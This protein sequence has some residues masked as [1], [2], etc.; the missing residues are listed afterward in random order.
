MDG[1]LAD[2]EPVHEAS[3]EATARSLGLDL[4]ANFHD[5]VLGR[6]EEASHRWLRE[7]CGLALSLAEWQAARLKAYLRGADAICPMRDAM[8]AWRLADDAGLRQAVVSN[9]DRMVVEVNLRRIGLSRPGLVSVARNDVRRGKPSAEPYLR[10]AYLLDVAPERTAVVEDSA[11]GARAGLAAGMT[12]FVMPHYHGDD[13][14]PVRPV[15][16]LATLLG[17]G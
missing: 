4:P 6:S 7:T 14:L 16:E 10:G 8:R 9:S 1:T 5:H 11:T 2:S 15:A 12:V 3:F 13:A 17:G